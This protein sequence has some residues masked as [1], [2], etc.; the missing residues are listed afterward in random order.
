MFETGTLADIR[1][2][3]P[4]TEQQGMTRWHGLEFTGAHPWD[5]MQPFRI[6]VGQ[7]VEQ[8]QQHTNNNKHH[9]KLKSKGAFGSAFRDII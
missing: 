8:Q 5:K 6:M 2:V 3:E 9:V 4:K 7:L 1:E